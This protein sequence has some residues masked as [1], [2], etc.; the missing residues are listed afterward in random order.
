LAKIVDITW[1]LIRDGYGIDILDD[2]SMVRWLKN[3]STSYPLVHFFRQFIP[4]LRW[5][6]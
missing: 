6:I 3:L 2:I 4:Q 5:E 1:T